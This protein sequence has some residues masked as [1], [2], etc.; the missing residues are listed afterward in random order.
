MND[1]A[2]QS[3]RTSATNQATATAKMR[4]ATIQRSRLGE[5]RA[6]PTDRENRRFRYRPQRGSRQHGRTEWRLPHEGAGDFSVVKHETT[7]PDNVA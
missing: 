7:P 1:L 5:R 2:Q 3:L 4:V 6:A